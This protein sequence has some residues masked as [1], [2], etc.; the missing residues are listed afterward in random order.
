MPHTPLTHACV[1]TT[2]QYTHEGTA[3][4]TEAQQTPSFIMN[5][6]FFK[7]Q[8]KSHLHEVFKSLQA[9]SKQPYLLTFGTLYFLL[10]LVFGTLI[11]VF[12][13][14]L[15]PFYFH[16]SL[17]FPVKQPGFQNPLFRDSSGTEGRAAPCV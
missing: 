1:T 16:P 14:S 12:P 13:M 6:T 7:A 3:L 15:T 4:D 9:H 10:G 5:S 11:H 17:R 8:F 2:Q